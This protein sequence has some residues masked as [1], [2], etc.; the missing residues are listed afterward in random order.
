MVQR[1][2][3][4]SVARQLRAI[5][6]EDFGRYLIALGFEPEK[7]SSFFY[8]YRRRTRRGLDLVEVQFD[9]YNRPK[10]VINF[11]TLPGDF[12]VDSYGRFVDAKDVSIAH[13]FQWG[14]LHRRAF[15]RQWFGVGGLSSL[16]SPENAARR[17]VFL[18]KDLFKQV[19]LWFQ[20]SETGANLSLLEFKRNQ[21]GA[22]RASMIARGVWPPDGW[23]AADEEAVKKADALSTRLHT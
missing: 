21:P 12:I 6:S 22:A 14:R 8:P 23:T 3:K 11:G 17:E 10:F 16:I 2:T 9:K 20:T 5:L 19:E 13:L 15:L 18:L 4:P 7:R 1:D